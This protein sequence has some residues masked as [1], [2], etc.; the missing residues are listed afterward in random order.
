MPRMPGTRDQD[1]QLAEALEHHLDEGRLICPHCRQRARPASIKAAT[2][3]THIG[4]GNIAM[5]DPLGSHQVIVVICAGC[6]QEV[7]Y[8]R[9]WRQ[10][11]GGEFGDRHPVTDWIVRVRPL[12]RG[13]KPFMSPE[14]ARF[15]GDY[16]AADR[17]SVV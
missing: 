6:D 5:P 7:V 12:G 15:V 14:A 11:V 8:A 1:A 17:K 4:L 3:A 2:T 9:R 10:E 16:E 13:A